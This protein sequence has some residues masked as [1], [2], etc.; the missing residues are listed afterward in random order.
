MALFC[1]LFVLIV[2]IIFTIGV[3]NMGKG[4]F[5]TFGGGLELIHGRAYVGL[6]KIGKISS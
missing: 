4:G 5:L 1:V 3:E 2:D 6:P